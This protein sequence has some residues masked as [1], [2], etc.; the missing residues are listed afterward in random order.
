MA[1]KAAP[2]HIFDRR[3]KLL[4]RARASR[5]PA[6]YFDVH[7]F[8]ARRL[9]DRMSI[10]KSGMHYPEVVELGCGR[11]PVLRAM[12]EAKSLQ[13]RGVT[14]YV[15][16]DSSEEIVMAAYRELRGLMPRGVK[17]EYTLLDEERISDFSTENSFDAVVSSGSYH[18]V[19][20]LDRAFAGVEKILRPDGMFL[21]CMAG[22]ETL[23]ELVSAFLYVERDQDGGVAP[24]ISPFVGPEDVSN[25]L[26]NTHFR[27]PVVDHE[28]CTKWFH[29]PLDVLN[30]LRTTGENNGLV[31][32]MRRKYTVVECNGISLPDCEI[33]RSNRDES[34]S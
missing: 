9:R 22:G 19:N 1:L 32:P 34:R 17:L 8:F 11:W 23:I 14:R 4:H 7:R 27:L 6:D 24:H 33:D 5:V 2:Q 10:L 26:V 15:L 28:S 29:T 18:W 3:I 31:L 12:L 30:Y 20:N 21:G 16:A 25:L 13:Y